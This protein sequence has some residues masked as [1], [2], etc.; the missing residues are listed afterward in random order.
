MFMARMVE[1]CCFNLV[2]TFD[3]ELSAAATAGTVIGG[4]L[5]L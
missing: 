3:A 5:I 4:C 2:R 1:T